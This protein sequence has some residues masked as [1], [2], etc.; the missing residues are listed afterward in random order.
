MD[1]AELRREQLQI[2]AVS[3]MP[4][5][6]LSAAHNADRVARD[7]GIDDVIRKPFDAA[8][9]LHIVASHCPRGEQS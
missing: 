5:V 9:L 1:G 6:L 4:F 2:A 7:L 8:N 3:S